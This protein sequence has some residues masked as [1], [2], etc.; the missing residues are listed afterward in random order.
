MENFFYDVQ[1]L[2]ARGWTKTLIENFL[3]EPDEWWS[4][5]HF[6]N[7]QGKKMYSADRVKQ[8]EMSNEFINAFLDSMRRRNLSKVDVKRI[9]A[10]RSLEGMSLWE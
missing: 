2:Q 3:G 8:I 4:V 6:R 7:F 1:G 10:S 5:N 9:T